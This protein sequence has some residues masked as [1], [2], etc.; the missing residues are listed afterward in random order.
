M[1]RVNIW[2]NINQELIN[3]Y[4]EIEPILDYI[5]TNKKMDFHVLD[6]DGLEDGEIS[7]NF[8]S[9]FNSKATEA[10]L[11]INYFDEKH[12]AFID[13]YDNVCFSEEFYLK[14]KSEIKEVV[15]DILLSEK[16]YVYV[17]KYMYSD[18]LAKLLTLNAPTIN[19]E[20]G[21]NIPDEIKNIYKASHINAYNHTPSGKQAFS[22]NKILGQLYQDVVSD[23]SCLNIKDDITDL[24]NLVQIPENKDIHI[25]LSTDDPEKEEYDKLYD[26]ISTLRKNG[27]NNKIFIDIKNRNKFLKSKLHDSNFDIIIEGL[28]F[29]DYNLEDLKEEDKLIDTMVKD[30]SY[31]DYSPYEK[32]IACYNIAKKFKQYKE[33]NESKE[34]SRRI[35]KILNN[36]YMVCVGYSN[37]L[38]ELLKRVGFNAYSYNVSTDVSYDDGFTLEEK[39][40]QL[41]GHERLI[42]NI[43]DPK[44]NIKGFYVT[45]PTWDNDL[46]EDYY[47]H[48]LMTFD[49]T[50]MEH[51][52]FRL[53]NED[54]IM[55]V[56]NMEEFSCKINILLNQ[57]RRRDDIKNYSDKEKENSAYSNVIY[58]ILNILQ[59]LA[60]D[61]YDYFK[62]KYP[63]ILKNKVNYEEANKFLTEAGYFFINNLGKDVSIDTT[64]EAACNVNKKVFGFD[65]EYNKENFYEYK[66]ELLEK[67]V[68]SDKKY[69]PYYYEDTNKFLK[70]HLEDVI[71]IFKQSFLELPKAIDELSNP[72]KEK[73]MEE[74]YLKEFL[75]LNPEEVFMH[76]GCLLFAK[77][78]NDVLPDTKY[79]VEYNKEEKRPSHVLLR[80]DE[81]YF[82][83][84][85]EE[86][87]KEE[88]LVPNKKYRD[89]M[90]SDLLYA[91]NNFFNP[92]GKVYDLLESIFKSNL[93]KYLSVAMEFENEHKK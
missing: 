84:T 27:Q 88:F 93:R 10:E 67:N 45:D 28:D 56:K 80:N 22:S 74:Q 55:N 23:S 64:I 78:M 85:Y 68:K 35:R 4:T 66:R 57:E 37:L 75:S 13:C 54:L 60:P 79:V 48:A 52:F 40:V 34:D 8:I 24:E 77:V 33:N 42:V 2:N 21:I 59:Q 9:K 81:V 5:K 58:G 14:H 72:K 26:I 6:N 18:E 7:T 3:Y 87:K 30:I 25:K 29:E 38:K 50:G 51:R 49:K 82:D 73:I 31:G 83:I 92:K 90:V 69:F 86:L 70:E 16:E 63:N 39:Q 11:K 17:N 20:E 15:E 32:F 44:Y 43:D 47:N 89:A 1:K 61:K 41:V 65:E 62:N 71:Y 53:E 12:P 76:G 19:F 46:E 36:D 91:E